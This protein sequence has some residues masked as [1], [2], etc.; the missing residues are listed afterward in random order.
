MKHGWK[1]LTIKK[2]DGSLINVKKCQ[3]C[4]CVRFSNNVCHR[5]SI[6]YF[7]PPKCFNSKKRIVN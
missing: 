6:T 3:Y 4:H 7:S 5:R 2:D 1:K